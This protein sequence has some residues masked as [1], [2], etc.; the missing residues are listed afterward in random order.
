V[1]KTD[2]SVIQETLAAERSKASFD[3]EQLM[4]YLE[5]SAQYVQ[6]KVRFAVTARY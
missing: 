4:I 5:G 1:I 2:Y 6:F 3:T